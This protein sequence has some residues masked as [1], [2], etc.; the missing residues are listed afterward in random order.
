MVQFY[1]IRQQITKFNEAKTSLLI[2]KC[3]LNN[4]IKKGSKKL[5]LNQKTIFT[6][7]YPIGVSTEVS[8]CRKIF[9]SDSNWVPS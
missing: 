9:L 4:E 3:I 6:G 1:K 7:S 5:F 2:F 8:E